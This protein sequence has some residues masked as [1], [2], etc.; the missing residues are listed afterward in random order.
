M[1]GFGVGSDLAWQLLGVLGYR[2][3]DTWEVGAGY[4]YVD[5]DYDADG[6]TYDVAASGILVAVRIQL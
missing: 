6:F 5:T 3:G 1:G 4:R 2:L